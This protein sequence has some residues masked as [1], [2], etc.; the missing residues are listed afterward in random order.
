MTEHST[1]QIRTWWADYRCTYGAKVEHGMFGRTPVYAQNSDHV[2]A[3]EQAHFAAGYN[4][5]PGGY[6]GSRRNCPAGIGGK[7][8]EQS[9][10][11]CSLHNYGLAWDVE[12]NYN[13][14]FRRTLSRGDLWELFNQGRTKYN[15]DILD[16]LHSVTNTHGE[17]L[18]RNL[19]YSIG[20]TMHTQLNVPPERQDVEWESIGVPPPPQPG[21]KNVYL[22]L[23]YGDGFNDQPERREDVAWLQ[24][25]LRRAGLGSIVGAVD[26]R[27]G[28]NTAA[29]VQV[30]MDDA[31]DG[32]VYGAMEHDQLLA[33]AYSGGAVLL[34]HTHDLEGT[35][36]TYPRLGD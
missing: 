28:N 14:H 31:V 13:P 8:C 23:E 36:G 9:G 7:D 12:Y 25:A 26:G 19:S 21:G 15:P 16:V 24:E 5:T 29:A 34:P 20:D 10:R 17:Q 1:S 3:L 35:T 11:N 4:S 33:T 32:R 6:I 18:F 27:Y 30:L 22:P 2:Y